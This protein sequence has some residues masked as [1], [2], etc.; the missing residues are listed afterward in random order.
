V[1]CAAAGLTD[2]VR[3]GVL[4]PLLVTDAAGQVAVL[5][6]AKQRVVLAALLLSA[7][8]TVSTDRMTELLWGA[9]P[10]PSAATAVR[11]YVMR[12]RQQIGPAGTRIVTR[13]GGYVVEVRDPAELDVAQA[14]RLRRDARAAAHAGRWPEASALLSAALSLWRGEPLADIPSPELAQRE[15]PHLAELKLQLTEARIDADLRLAR[16]HELVAELRQLV[17]EQPLREHLRAQLMIALY[18][19]GRQAEALEMYRNTRATL[20]DELGLEPGHE[21]QELHQRILAGDP[22]LVAAQ[23][24]RLAGQLPAAAQITGKEQV[25]PRQLP[26]GIGRFI[27]RAA[28]LKALDAL[29]DQ[30]AEAADTVVISA[31]GGMAGIGKTALAVHWAHRVADK[32]PDGQLYV[33]LRGFHLSGRPV[34]PAAALR[35]LLDALG[36][37]AGQIPAGLDAQAGLYRSLLSG[38]RMLVLLDN[39]RDAGQVRA[40][41]PGSSGCLVLVTSRGQLAGLAAAEGAHLL[42][43]DLLTDAEARELLAVRLG[44]ARI[45]AEPEADAELIGLCARLPLALAIAAAR[46]AA[47]PGFRLSA[48]AAELKD[49]RRK[50]DALDA[51][52]TAASA[53]AVFSW[54]LR[55]L[56]APAARMFGLLGLHP[57]PDITI[58]AAASLAGIPPPRARRAL[59]E[60]AEDHLIAELAPGRFALHDLLR[61]YAAEQAYESGS[62]TAPGEA[63]GRMLGYYVATGYTA[64]LLVNPAREVLGLGLPAIPAGVSTDAPA[65]SA[66]ALAWYAAEHKNLLAVTEQAAATG[67]DT[68]ACLLCW[69]LADFLDRRGSWQEWVIAQQ[70]ALSAATRLGDRALQARAARGLGRASTELGA[71]QDARAHLRLALDLDRQLGNREGCANTHLALARVFEYQDDYR[72]ALGHARQALDLLRAA[73][74]ITGQA[75]ALNGTG[76]FHAQLGSYAEA[77]SC[78]E[79]ALSLYRLTQDR[80]GEAT[81]SDSLAYACHHLGNQSRA[82]TCYQRA[83]EIFQDLGDRPNLAGTLT[84]LGDAYQAAGD[85]GNAR[86]T[87]QRALAIL[88]DPHHKNASQIRA[89][90]RPLGPLPESRNSP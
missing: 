25:I 38:R 87:W 63:I 17:A 45:S 50:L 6:A 48:L 15:A 35:A 73:G 27:G 16:H 81:A 59:G 52:D 62:D 66:Q 37:P 31:I 56:S 33:N 30:A 82:I 84:R 65:D 88:D 51:G 54:S 13:P 34:P 75:R 46:I 36:M 19:C 11:N 24:P 77:L 69:I 12:L 18:G 55:G 5:P 43:L 40:L 71:L 8:A 80:R 60:L 42:T 10:P 72:R 49:A 70:A 28:E 86:I 53:R 57:G 68:H 44:A 2:T 41:L 83:V 61:A 74:D 14:G 47:R 78:C 29:L 20:T 32:F 4:G 26:A 39:A 21:L 89:K 1:D 64:A 23:P 9:S 90:L 58:P 22:G 76:W 79:Q 7:N 3:F 67:F 85:L